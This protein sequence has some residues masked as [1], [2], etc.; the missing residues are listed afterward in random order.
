MND[1]TYIRQRFEYLWR[2]L[3]LLNLGFGLIQSLLNK[4]EWIGP[5][6]W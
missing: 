1:G 4:P 6:T 5:L 3:H 2:I